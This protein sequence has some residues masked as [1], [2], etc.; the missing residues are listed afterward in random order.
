MPLTA[1]DRSPWCRCRFARV[2]NVR[3]CVRDFYFIQLRLREYIKR[4]FRRVRV[5][6]DFI[7]RYYTDGNFSLFIIAVCLS[8]NRELRK[9]LCEPFLQSALSYTV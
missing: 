7:E 4:R 8:S 5:P 6:S 9:S 1:R 3:A 2:T